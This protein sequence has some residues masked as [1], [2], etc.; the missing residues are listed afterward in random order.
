METSRWTL[1]VRAQ[2]SGP[3]AH[4]ALGALIRCYEN[5][6]VTLIR[7]RGFPPD[8]TADDLKQAFFARMLERNDVERLDRDRGHFRGWL[9]TAVIRFVFNDW[10]RWYRK[11]AKLAAPIVD[12]I[13][14]AESAPYD[15]FDVAYAWET[16][17]PAFDKLRNEQSDKGRFEALQRYL[18]GPQLDVVAYE[19]G[20]SV[21][22]HEPHCGGGFRVSPDVSA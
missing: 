10:E 13:A 17:R 2:G 16:Y 18:F 9:K 8:Q 3:E 22:R 12:D 15:P 6:V 11:A 20:R 19:T 4:A 5:S 14:A 1:I 7:H 21:A